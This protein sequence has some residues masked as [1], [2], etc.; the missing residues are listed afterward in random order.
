MTISYALNS[1]KGSIYLADT[2][3]MN[4][5]LSDAPYWLRYKEI[6]KSSQ[7][8]VIPADE[9]ASWADRVDADGNFYA[10]L[11][12]G[13]NGTNR[14][15]TFT[16]NAEPEKDPE[17]PKSTVFVSC[18]GSDPYFEV[19][20][21]QTIVVKDA[22]GGPVKNISAQPAEKYSL[23]DL[24]VGNYTLEGEIDKISIIL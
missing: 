17:Y 2:C 5:S 10:I 12:A 3:L 11:Y 16:T 6:V 9:I 18:T 13:D 19:S 8:L 20:K 15:F 21:A 4:I 7:P 1:N 22:N 24:P 14:T 23:K